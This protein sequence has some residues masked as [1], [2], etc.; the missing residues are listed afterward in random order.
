MARA[1]RFV[2]KFDDLDIGE[3]ADGVADSE[4]SEQE[5]SKSAPPSKQ[6][7]PDQK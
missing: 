6:S 1:Q 5:S 7:M 3:K 2:W 4:S